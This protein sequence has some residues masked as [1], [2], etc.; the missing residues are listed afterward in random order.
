MAEVQKREE[1]N[2]KKMSL[3]LLGLVEWLK[4]KSYMVIGTFLV[5][6]IF[7]VIVLLTSKF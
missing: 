7:I 2:E 1:D 6:L 4:N 5:I 3:S